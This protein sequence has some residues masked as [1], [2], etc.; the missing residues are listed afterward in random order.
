MRFR[1]GAFVAALLA[2]ELAL[3][4]WIFFAPTELGGS[5]TYSVTSGVSMQPLLYRN[6]LALVRA[7]TTY[8]VGDVVLYH[9]SV[10][11]KPVLHRIILI[12]NDQ[13]YFKGDNN[14]FVDPGYATRSELVGKLWV[15]VPELGSAFSWLGQ[16]LHAGL[17]AG[18]ASTFVVLTGGKPHRRRRRRR[19]HAGAATLP[20]S[21]TRNGEQ[22]WPR[23]EEEPGTSTSS[24]AESG[25]EAPR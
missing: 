9:S 3:G 14:N 22:P 23:T 4:L 5:S 19:H 8:A 17:L 6:D 11:G 7:Q 2:A 12:Q 1:P 25:G 10:L 21:P 18:L 20:R 13:Y 15:H 24:L 16:P